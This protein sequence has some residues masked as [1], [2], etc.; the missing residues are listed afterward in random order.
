MSRLSDLYEEERAYVKKLERAEK[1]RANDRREF[2]DDV[3]PME[4]Y[5][6]PIG[7]KEEEDYYRKRHPRNFS[8]PV[9]KCIYEN[10][11]EIRSYEPHEAGYDH[12]IKLIERC[13][14]KMDARY[15]KAL[16]LSGYQLEDLAAT[17]YDILISP[18]SD[19]FD[20]DGFLYTKKFM[21]I[22][23]PYIASLH[24]LAKEYTAKKK[25]IFLDLKT[26]TEP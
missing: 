25:N 22:L 26:T 20:Q 5:N 19:A 14:S 11:G 7:W 18:K 16:K 1:K 17:I 15:I 23:N 24:K 2:T 12:M 10:E 6:L 3:K 9:T 8:Q 21:E 13:L 4:D